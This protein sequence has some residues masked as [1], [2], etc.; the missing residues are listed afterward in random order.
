MLSSQSYPLLKIIPLCQIPA[1]HQ[2][3]WVERS[4]NGCP[5]ISHFLHLRDRKTS[6]AGQVGGQRDQFQFQS[7]SLPVPYSR[8]AVALC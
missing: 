1:Q 7:G 2:E 5:A 6:S 4:S 8:Y 3:D